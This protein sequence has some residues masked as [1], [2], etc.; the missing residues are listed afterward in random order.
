MKLRLLATCLCIFLINKVELSAQDITKTCSES[1]GQR[2]PH[3]GNECAISI[4]ISTVRDED[5]IYGTTDKSLES[6]LFFESG[7]RILV[8]LSATN[9]STKLINITVWDYFKPFVPRLMENDISVSYVKGMQKEANKDPNYTPFRSSSSTHSLLPNVTRSLGFLDL[10]DWYGL[11]Q[12]GIYHLR[13][14]YRSKESG[15][16]LESNEVVFQIGQEKKN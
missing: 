9:H 13:V 12:P 6:Q 14:I 4:T 11:L 7:E 15:K 5:S 8:S 2:K 1:T 10:T 16:P 3:S